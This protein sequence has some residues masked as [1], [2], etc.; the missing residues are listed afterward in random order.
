MPNPVRVLSIDGGGMRGL[1]P[2]MV[3]AEIEERTGKPICQLF[4]L[5]A[6]TSTG[7]ILALGLTKPDGDHKPA[8]TAADL[9][10]LYNREGKR[11][12]SRSPWDRFRALENLLEEKYPSGGIDEVLGEYFGDVQ[13]SEALTNV[14]LTSYEI[15]RR[16]AFLFKS[17]RAKE[18]DKNDFPMRLAARATAAAPTYF[19][20]VRIPVAGPE[21]Y[22]ALVDGGVYANNPGMCAYVEARNLFSDRDD[23]LLVSLGTGTLTRPIPYDEAKDWG[24]ARWAQPILDVV[25]DG[26]SDTVDYQLQQL[27]RKQEHVERYFRFQVQLDEGSDD[28]DDASKTNL[29]ALRLLAEGLIREREKELDD[30]CEQLAPAP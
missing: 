26:V 10:E 16:I 1:I 15:E 4:D 8:Y 12:F 6:G 3:L 14:L 13:L 9:T 25:F 5:V 24:L 17:H 2:A 22:Y 30:L 29:R 28:M 18:D 7:G 11:I 27:C 23:F 20:P 21:E 19:E